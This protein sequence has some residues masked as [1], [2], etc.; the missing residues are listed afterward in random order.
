MN[1]SRSILAAAA[2][3]LLA[4]APM[5]AQ[6]TIQGLPQPSPHATLTQTVGI[7]TITVDYHRLVY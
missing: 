5:A 4:A 3:G 2:V 7:S 1:R 6:Q